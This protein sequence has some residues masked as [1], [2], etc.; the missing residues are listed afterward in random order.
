MTYSNT[1]WNDIDP[2][3]SPEIHTPNLDELAASSTVFNRAYVQ[4]R[5]IFCSPKGVHSLCSMTRGVE[6]KK[7]TT[8]AVC[9]LW[10][11]PKLVPDRST[12]GYNT[13]LC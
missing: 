13:V 1:D 5:Q 2:L 6:L 3:S 4:A 7:Q 8:V 9:S 12:T 11:K 10:S